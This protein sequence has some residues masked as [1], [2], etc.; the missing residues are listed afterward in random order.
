M[1]KNAKFRQK[2]SKKSILA[3]MAYFLKKFQDLPNF[4]IIFSPG[5]LGISSKYHKRATQKAKE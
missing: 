3:K 5:A 4:W 2:I 1:G